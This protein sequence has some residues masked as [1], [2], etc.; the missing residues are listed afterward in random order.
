M[1][2]AFSL[3]QHP[4]TRPWLGSSSAEGLPG[5]DRLSGLVVGRPLETMR[6]FAPRFVQDPT[7]YLAPHV[8]AGRI[9]IFSM[10]APIDPIM[11]RRF[12]DHVAAI[13]GPVITT[14]DHEPE[15]SMNATVFEGRYRAYYDA[16]AGVANNRTG[17]IV[18]AATGTGTAR[19]AYRNLLDRIPADILLVDGYNHLNRRT[20]PDIFG[21][22]ADKARARDLPWGIAEWSTH[23]TPEERAG[24][25]RV[26]RH[27]W[28]QPAN[29]DLVVVCWFD[30]DGGAQAGSSG[31]RLERALPDGWAPVNNIAQAPTGGPRYVEDVLTPGVFAAAFDTERR[32]I[33]PLRSAA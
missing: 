14:I 2:V 1:P 19:T 12:A 32:D 23:G 31:W 4:P 8:A 20:F 24:H 30:S 18:M 5:L 13:G 6:V 17:P 26:A 11:Y 25:V 7:P 33:D 21:W 16:M 15:N 29:N 9:P 28:E 3:L 10:K 22:L 27:Y